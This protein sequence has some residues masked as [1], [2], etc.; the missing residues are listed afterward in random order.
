MSERVVK[1]RL[2]AQVNDYEKGML[3]AAKATQSVGSE[4]EKLAQKKEAFDVVGR[5]LV[6]TG[7]ALTATTALSIKAASDWQSAWVGVTKTVDGTDQEMASL[8]GQLRGLTGV[9]PAAH[10]EIAAVAEA[11]GQLGIER[12]NVAAFTKTMIDMGQSTNLS[13]DDAATSMA[14]F[15]NIMGTSTEN[16]SNLGS[17][18]VGLGNNYATTEREIM[19]MSMRLAGA[20]KQI[21]L[22]EG[23]TLGLATALSSVGIEAEA[24]GS[25]MSKVMID[26]AA[27]VETG[28][29]KLS[30]FATTAGM[31]ADQFAEKWRKNPA[32]ALAAFVKGLSNAEA[33]GSSTLGVL[34]DLGITEVRMRDA[35]LRSASAA[36]MFAGAMADG[37]QAF[38]EN[39]ALAIEAAKRYETVESK[40]A[41]AGNAVRDAAIDFGEVFLPAVGAAADG[42][43]EFSGF[44]GDL[45][46]PL[47]GIL[48]VLGTT[49]GLIAI[50]GGTALLAVP[51]IAEFKVALQ[52]LGIS[53]R[54][55]GLVGGGAIIALTAL[56]TVV[57]AVA[58][59]QAA[60]EQKAQSYADT[61]AEGTQK[62]TAAT[63]DLIAENINAKESFLGLD[64]TSMAEA[65]KDLGLSLDTVRKAIEG[66]ADAITELDA[67]TQKAIDSYNFWDNETIALHSSAELLRGEVEKET[68]ALDTAAQMARDKAEA[69][70]EA[71]DSADSASEAYTAEKDVI[72]ELNTELSGLID[73]INEANGVGQDAVTANARW[74]SALAG[75]SDEVQKQKDA[76]EEANGTLDGFKL[77]LDQNTEAGSANAAMLADTASAA[78]NAAKAQ[79]EQDKATMSSKDAADKY[80]ETL[81][82]QRQAFIDSATEAGFNQEAVKALADEIFA[83]PSETDIKVLA[84]TTSAEDKLR[85]LKETLDAI[86]NVTYKR[87]QLDSFTVG[88]FD[89]SIPGQ[90]TG[91]PVIGP[92]TGTSDSVPRMLSNGEHIIT[93]A[94]VEAFG[95][96]GAVEQIRASALSGRSVSEWMPTSERTVQRQEAGAA[97]PASAS[98]PQR[99]QV[100]LRLKDDLSRFIE[101]IVEESNDGLGSGLR[102]V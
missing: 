77:S 17:A 98:T 85:I 75:I 90:A 47:Q 93:A 8:E 89:V 45:P 97:V 69:T 53:M 81:R 33:Q 95:G 41:I 22:S 11:A 28:D 72:S 36:D 87:V 67:V 91:G 50:T 4:A 20:G 5:G 66:D 40:I 73:T 92:G 19:D 30:Q 1:V 101:A 49:V 83:L 63:R 16:V 7:A 78:Q 80:Y 37:N 23:Q 25:A 13:A 68:G 15:M 65:A 57:G 35:L 94:E 88:N 102:G 62:V 39:N 51:K 48:G 31:S 58:S 42:V 29:E 46:D 79:F 84:D 2:M 70:R 12:E 96:H 3:A 54:T 6:V 52:N 59:A 14:R 64:T 26:I 74:Q 82:N 43:S 60:A 71:A 18:L 61:L 99:V 86:P 100:A 21:G 9:L 55:I 27:S 24:G 32:D 38:D 76:Y 34:A 10:D 56:V 44:M